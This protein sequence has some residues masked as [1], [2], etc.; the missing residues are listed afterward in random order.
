MFHCEISPGES[1]EGRT[2]QIVKLTGRAT[3][4]DVGRGKELL[5]NAL[6]LGD[7][8]LIDGMGLN[9]I[10]FSWLQL[11][12]AAHRTAESRGKRLSFHST[13]PVVVEAVEAAGFCRRQQ[14]RA[15]QGTTDCLW[16]CGRSQ[17]G[18]RDA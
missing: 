8:V 12:C 10:D 18:G 17:Q 3:I 9:D 7:E 5:L 14:C 13:T 11:L 16:I 6:E 4:N 15:A 1:A 2:R